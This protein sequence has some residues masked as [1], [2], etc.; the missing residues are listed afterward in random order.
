MQ[1]L[2][3]Y[4]LLATHTEGWDPGAVCHRSTAGISPSPPPLSKKGCRVQDS[5][6]ASLFLFSPTSQKPGALTGRGQQQLG[7]LLPPY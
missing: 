7:V 3:F 1:V 2:Q 6:W 4:P 5:L